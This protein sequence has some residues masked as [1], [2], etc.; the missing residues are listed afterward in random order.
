MC[1]HFFGSPYIYIYIY[2]CVCV[3]VCLNWLVWWTN[4]AVARFSV[5]AS[6]SMLQSLFW[7]FMLIYP[8]Q[9]EIKCQGIQSHC[10]L[11]S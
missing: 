5:S 9:Y 7:Q 3:C 6:P 11:I 2:V 8:H 10:P 4:T 1:V